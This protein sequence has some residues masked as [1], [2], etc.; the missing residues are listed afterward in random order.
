MVVQNYFR[1]WDNFRVFLKFQILKNTKND[2]RC[3]TTVLIYLYGMS[4]VAPA[5]DRNF[6]TMV[7]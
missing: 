7:P 2:I 3:D 6:R 5:I 1:N 4:Y